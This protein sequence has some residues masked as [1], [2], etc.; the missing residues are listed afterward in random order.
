MLF[1]PSVPS[2]PTTTMIDTGAKKETTDDD[3]DDWG[4]FETFEDPSDV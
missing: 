4:D 1:P 2:Q 3:G